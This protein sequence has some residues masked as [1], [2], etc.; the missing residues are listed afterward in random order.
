[1]MSLRTF[2]RPLAVALTLAFAA[3]PATALAEGN[4]PRRDEAKN[5][6]EHKKDRAQFPIA[7]DKFQAHVE[8]RITKMRERIE[9]RMEKRNVLDAKRVE[10]RKNFEAGAGQ[11]REAA[12]RAGADGT[13]TKEEAKQVRDLAKSLQQKARE[14]H[15][16]GGK[17]GGADA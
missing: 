15:G 7:A 1:M 8:K 11:V 4:H 3:V 17:K 9:S 2:V 16:R 13:V 5:K 10:V 14:K 12:K 6:G